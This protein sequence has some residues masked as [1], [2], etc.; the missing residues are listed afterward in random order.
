L[1]NDE[2]VSNLAQEAVREVRKQL[3]EANGGFVS[4]D[5]Q[6]RYFSDNYFELLIGSYFKGK[7][8]LFTINIYWAITIPVK[9][10]Y[11]AIG[12]GKPFAEYLLSR[13]LQ[14]RVIFA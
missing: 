5:E 8:F 2:T 1:E 3:T 11:A 10:R 4:S 13:V 9:T 7:P 14:N 6:Q 12:C